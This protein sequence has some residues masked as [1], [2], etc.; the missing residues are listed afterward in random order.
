[1]QMRNLAFRGLRL[2]RLGAM[3]RSGRY[4]VEGVTPLSVWDAANQIAR[5]GGDAIP[6]QTLFANTR[7]GTA[8]YVD[9]SGKIV[10][11]TALNSITNHYIDGVAH[12]LFQ[13]SAVTRAIYR[14]DLTNAAWVKTNMAAAKTSVGADGATNAATRLTASEGNATVLQSLTHASTARSYTAYIK[15]VTGSGDIQMTMD[16]GSTW[17]T[18]ATSAHY[19]RVT[20]PTQT[21]AN[22]IFGFRIVTSGDA[23]DIDY[24]Q[25]EDGVFPTTVIDGAEGSAVTRLADAASCPLTTLPVDTTG[26]TI[27]IEGRAYYDPN[28]SDFNRVFQIDDG[29]NSNNIQLVVRDSSNEMAFFVQTGGVTQ[30]SEKMIYVSGDV[31]SAAIR[32][33][34]NDCVLSLG[35]SNSGAGTSVTLP[36]GL[37]TFRWAQSAGGS[38][39]NAVS[40][41]KFRSF[42]H[43]FTTAE[44]DAETGA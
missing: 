28:G 5:S 34:A 33:T 3:M 32:F 37:N 26:G 22:P 40:I 1:M 31:F 9:A 23:V 43:E 44:M 18:V 11:Q 16:N 35:G 39:D 19:T 29:T 10:T 27:F 14:R 20:I 25:M 24:N 36:H 12:A 17:T 7:N 21:L 13:P 41:S 38:R 8:T 2:P 30:C 42:A 6:L 4:S 15:R